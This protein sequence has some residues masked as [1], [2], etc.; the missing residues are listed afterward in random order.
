MS[1]PAGLARKAALRLKPTGDWWRGF[2]RLADP[3]IALASLTSLFLGA[4]LAASQQRLAWGWL[5]LTVFG[6]LAIE[7]GKHAS[8]DIFDL[9]GDLLV[10]PHERSPFSGGRRVI[11][12]GLLT[13]RQTAVIAVAAYAVA[14]ACGLLI[15]LLREPGILKLGLFG[16]ACAYFYNAPPVRLSSR[17]L[18][19]IAVGLCY[20]PLICL[21]TAWVQLRH[22]DPSAA[23]LGLPLGLMIAA[24]L[25]ANEFPDYNADFS[26]GKFNMVVRLGRPRAAA[27]YFW[28]SVCAGA[29]VI[30][31]GLSDFGPGLWLG[32]LALIPAGL[33]SRALILRP[34]EIKSII[35]A[36]K[37]ALA[38]F[39]LMA[40]A[41]S[42]GLLLV[43]WP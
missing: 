11:V 13:K 12:D 25:V 29:F 18:G 5:A 40:V 7:I 1:R 4:C 10:A 9:R 23:A 32:L 36:Q 17:G 33:A 30:A 26:S 39:V 16:V 6:I 21:G 15:C 14:A 34:T 41:E 38:A 20:G 8:G 19:E 24:F 22:R 35:E 31:L 27:V 42:A 37:L 3:K 2:W 43:R 28:L